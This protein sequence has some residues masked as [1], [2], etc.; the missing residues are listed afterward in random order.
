LRPHSVR[1]SKSTDA[2]LIEAADEYLAAIDALEAGR[3][4]LNN[5][6]ALRRFLNTFPE[7]SYNPVVG[8]QVFGLIGPNGDPH[9]WDRV[10]EALRKE[11]EVAQAPKSEE[12][13]AADSGSIREMTHTAST[14]RE[15]YSRGEV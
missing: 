14:F 15:A 9:Y 4:K 10:V 3:Q 2:Q 7:H 1:A 12:P 11:A 8:G 5:A 13:V 6:I